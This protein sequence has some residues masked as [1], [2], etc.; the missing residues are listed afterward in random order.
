MEPTQENTRE[1]ANTYGLL[2]GDVSEPILIPDKGSIQVVQE[3]TAGKK[4]R[5]WSH[6]LG[7]TLNSWAKEIFAMRRALPFWDLVVAENRKGLSQY[8][9][10]PAPDVIQV[11]F[12]EGGFD[13]IASPQIRAHRL[14][15]I[16][17]KDVNRPALFYVQDTINKHLEGRV[18]PRLLWEEKGS[19]IG[20]YFVPNSLI[21]ALWLQFTLAVD[22]NKKYER[23][24]ECKTWFEVSLDAARTNRRYCKDACRFKAY[25]H[26]Q[27]EAR[28]LSAEGMPV[29]KIAKRLDSDA[30]TVN[31]WIV[32]RRRKLGAKK[33]ARKYPNKRD[34]PVRVHRTRP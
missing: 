6:G 22:G 20:L 34:A 1:F 15:Y 13:L 16:P 30:A 27:A 18:S 2:G 17:A 9:H 3:R 23:C 14:Q 33:A 10:R 21:G 12:P 8:V 4:I 32:S 31:S 26:R 11:R 28:R 24:T 19:R 29:K 5:S 25:R 7:E